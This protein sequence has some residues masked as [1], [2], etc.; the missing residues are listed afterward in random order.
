MGAKSVFLPTGRLGKISGLAIGYIVAGKIALLL[1]PSHVYATAVWPAAGIALAGIL[2]LGRWAWPGVFLGALAVNPGILFNVNGVAQ[3]IFLSTSVAA[4]ATLQALL[5]AF[6]IRRYAGFPSPP[7]R[8]QNV[9]KTMLLGGP[10]S[11]LVSASTGVACMLMTGI[12]ETGQGLTAW[13][14]WWLGDAFGVLVVIPLVSAW[15]IEKHR[16]RFRSRLSVI[17]PLGIAVA[18]TVFL[19]YQVRNDELK[20]AQLIFERQTD[21]LAQALKEVLNTYL[22]D[23]YA[24]EGLF[25]AS[26]QV[27]RGEFRAFVQ[28]MFPRHPGIKALEWIPRVPEAE[29][30]RYQAM[31]RE[32]GYV[33]FRI[34][35]LNPRGE[36]VEA[37]PRAEYFPV[38]YLEP[39]LGNEAALGFDLASNPVRHEALNRSRDLGAPVASARIKLVQDKSEQYGVLIVLPIYARG[40][41]LDTVE[42]RRAQLSGFALGVFR[43]TDL[44]NT[45]LQSFDVGGISYGLYDDMAPPAE[46]LLFTSNHQDTSPSEGLPQ[47]SRN[48][49]RPALRS[50]SVLEFAQRRWVMEFSPTAGFLDELELW[51]AHRILSGGLLFSSL[52]GAFLLV[53]AGRTAMIERMVAERTTELSA[54]NA[55]LASEIDGRRKI[56]RARK[57]SEARHRAIVDTAVDGIITIDALGTVRSFNPAAE[58]IFGYSADEVIGCNVKMLQPEPYHSRHDEYLRNYLRTGERKIIGIGREVVGLRKDGTEF[59]LDLAVSEVLLDDKRLF[60]GIIRDITERKQTEADLQAAKEQAE[61]ANRAKSE[62]LASMSHEIRTPMNA[63]IG[64]AE[65]LGETRLEPEQHEYVRI[66]KSAGENLL[67]LINDILDISKLEAGHFELEKIDFNLREVLEKTCEILALRAH[68]KGLE[69]ACHLVSDVPV[70]LVGDALRLRQVLVN[71]V[72]N[73]IK[74]TEQGEIVVEIRPGSQPQELLF[75]VSDTGI[76]IPAD[77]QM[78]IFERFTQVDASTT[79]Q[80]GGT[81]LGLNISQRIVEAMGG[82]IWVESKSGRGSTFYFTASFEVRPGPEE[83]V[84]PPPVSMQGLRMLVVDD[85]ATNRLVLREVLSEWGAEVQEA[86]DGKQGLAELQRARNSAAPFDLVL[87]DC[88]MPGMDG[89]DVAQ[90]I[91]QDSAFGGMTVMMLTSDNRAGDIARARQL[92]MAGYMVKPIKRDDLRKAI[93]AALAETH[94]TTSEAVPEPAPETGKRP[95]HILLVDDSE[96]NRLL[97]SAYLKKTPHTL[98]L[99]E[100]GEVAVTKFKAGDFDLVLM[101]MQMPVK[102]GYAATREIRQWEATGDLPPTPVVALTAYA[103]KDDAQKSLDAGCTGHLTKPIKKET[104]LEAIESISQTIEKKG[105][106]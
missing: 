34:F 48:A 18:I 94:A 22:D 78:T 47:T 102:D 3:T 89:F 61:V 16:Q 42:A 15:C 71:L 51:E 45:A 53:W 82:K 96:D 79:R 24:I 25:M 93:A 21:H 55:R 40:V 70:K 80:Y 30:E 32:D 46:R 39:H 13:W 65:L 88:R 56:D 44:V 64:M 99:A 19:F 10:L 23:L 38:Y 95:L 50:E 36:P 87:L 17:L 91:Q 101:D 85:C 58:E 9:F 100:N 75:S 90:Q 62:F 59:P 73:A 28:E 97:V 60:T 103:L 37:A 41:P 105:E 72:G 84:A 49:S 7:D 43:V 63:I 77:K 29:G 6:L 31:A 11:C 81:G 2:L 83:P 1:A 106:S 67:T 26:R 68:K 35:E 66:F 86:H 20:R 76:G 69:L 52:L 104:L 92:G 57:E 33:D 74:F 8:I 12:L 4:A 98:E 27:E 5:G 14:T 54:A